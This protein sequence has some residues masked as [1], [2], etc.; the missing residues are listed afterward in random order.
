MT[1]NCS[2]CP[3]HKFQTWYYSP[4]R[5]W[6]RGLIST[7]VA[8]LLVALLKRWIIPASCAVLTGGWGG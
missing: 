8:S 4:R 1:C 2:S 6:L 7:V 3:L 5:R